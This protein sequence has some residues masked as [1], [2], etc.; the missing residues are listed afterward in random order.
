MQG[1]HPLA[2]LSKVL[3]PR[4]QGLSTYEKE[5]LAILLAVDQWRAYLQYSEF[6]I[7]TDQKSLSQLTEQRLHTPWQQKVFAK[8]LGLSYK[9][10]YRKGVG[11]RAADALSRQPT[12]LC[13]AVSV[14][15]PQWLQTVADS[16]AHDSHAQSIIAKLLLDDQAVPHFSFRDGLLR[17][18]SRIWVGND[19]ALQSQ[20][21]ESLHSS[22][23]GGHS[24]V[25]VTYRRLKQL[26]A[27]QGMKATV[28]AFV[29]ACSICQQSK[30]D[31]SKLPGL[32]QPLPVPGRAWKVISMDFIEGLP[33]S[34]GFNCILVVVDIFSKYSHFLGLKHPL[35]AASVAKTFL[36]GVYKLHGMPM[37][38]VSDRDPIFT[39]A[40]W[41]ELFKQA[42][43]EL[44][45]STA[46][47]PQSD[48]QTERV[49]QCL[50]TFLRCFV[51]ACPRQWSTWLD[52]AQFWYNTSFHSAVGGSPFEVMYGYPPH[53][54]GISPADDQ[55]VTDLAS[56]LQDREL[57]SDLIHQHL[58]RAK[59]RMKK[60]ADGHRSERQ[61]QLNDWV[62]LKMQP[63]VQSSLAARS[64]QKL[65]FKFFGP[66]RIIGKVGTV[67][68]RLELPP[69]SAVHP[70]FHVSQLKKAVGAHRS[71]TASLPPS[72][73]AWSIPEAILQRR[74]I[75]KWAT[76]VQQGL[77]KWSGLPKSLATWEDLEFLRQQFPRATVW[78]QQGAQ[79]G[80][81]VSTCPADPPAAD[82]TNSMEEASDQVGRPVRSKTRSVR[83][84]GPEWRHG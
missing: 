79:G 55:P 64:N 37:A 72:S 38:I 51:H 11:N 25:P 6:Q 62:Y 41:Q 33:V 75:V 12:D 43:V 57:M 42:K 39:S 61:F 9:I 67:A 84:Y 3:G 4:S 48:G 66:F 19:A 20:L 71:V 69:T 10:V 26:F 54:F 73:A 32:L 28:H 40:F 7:W 76:A 63:Y 29:T 49:N 23:V 70:V 36:S 65:A 68:Y 13:A 24:G 77:I 30:P 15:Q 60:Q 5:Y 74:T 56:W 53:Q 17:Y 14:V 44:R 78:R 83:V 52:L 35:T 34:G 59:Q 31:R 21:I 47:H 81:N 18:K 82:K 45:M 16:Y 8:L 27:W 2:F 1:G 80:G 46:Y 50:E 58:V 22:A